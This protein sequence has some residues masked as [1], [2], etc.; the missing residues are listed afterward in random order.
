MKYLTLVVLLAVMQTPAP[1]PRKST[2]PSDRASQERPTIRKPI[3][4][5]PDQ[6]SSHDAVAENPQKPILVREIPPVSVMKDWWDR[7]YIVFTGILMVVGI[8][9]VR[10]AYKTLG[11]SPRPIRPNQLDGKQQGRLRTTFQVSSR[12]L[13]YWERRAVGCK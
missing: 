8:I 11:E 1:A 3:S 7:T 5:S 6:N 2:N 13:A 9:G 10:A 12:Q 4:A